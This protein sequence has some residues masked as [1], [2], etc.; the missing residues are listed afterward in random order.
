VITF[1][2]DVGATDDL[3]GAIVE[4]RFAAGMVTLAALDNSGAASATVTSL[5]DI[6]LANNTIEVGDNVNVVMDVVN[7]TG[8]VTR[9]SFAR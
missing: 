5:N 3:T 7:N 9:T 8:G 2:A 4:P 6:T 1:G